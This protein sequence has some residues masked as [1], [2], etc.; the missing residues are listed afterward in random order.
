MPNNVFKNSSNNSDNKI[1]TSLFVQK[2]YLRHNYKEANIEEDI[3]LKNQFR[4]KN[5]PDPLSIREAASKNYVDNLFNNPSISKITEHIDLN[6][7][8]ITNARFIQVN[9]WPQI[10]SHLTAKLYVDTEIDQSSL[11]RNNQ[12]NDFININLTNT[13]SITSNTQ[14]VNDN[15]VITKAYVDQFHQENER[16][17][18][19]VGLDFYDES[20][21]L[22]KNNQDNDLNDNKLTNINSITINNN[23]TDDNH[24]SKKKYIDDELDKKNNS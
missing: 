16:S 20:S 6:D 2:P 24:V 13:N 7:R 10:D 3:D 9:Q 8:N 21:D 15:Q 23:P 19:D 22:V 5:L 11:V 12:D 4:I 17:R 18:R 14:A 1:D